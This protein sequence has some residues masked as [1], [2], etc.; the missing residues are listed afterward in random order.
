[1]PDAEYEEY[2]EN[3]EK[4]LNSDKVKVF[5]SK[6]FAETI[7]NNCIEKSRDDNKK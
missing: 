3:I 2:L 6:Y 7:V 1:M 5:S 4:Y